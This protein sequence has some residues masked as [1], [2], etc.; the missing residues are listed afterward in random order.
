VARGETDLSELEVVAQD[1]LDT[2]EAYPNSTLANLYDPDLMPSNLRKAHQRLDRAVDRFYRRSGFV[3]ER[4]RLEH[5]FGLYEKM[6]AQ[7]ATRKR[8]RKYS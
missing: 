5:L 4:E 3:S 2:R 6:C 1:V 7:R 8:R